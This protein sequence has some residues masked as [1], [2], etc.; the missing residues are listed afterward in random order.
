MVEAM[1]RL[2]AEWQAES[3]PSASIRIGIH[4]GSILAGVDGI[5]GRGLLTVTNTG[6]ISGT[7]SS[8]RGIPGG[9]IWPVPNLR[10]TLSHNAVLSPTWLTGTP[11]K[12]TPAVF[13]DSL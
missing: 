8:G 3:L 13:S 5:Y 10:S 12:T 1:R 9:G 2:N 11:S 7:A 6:V 4:T